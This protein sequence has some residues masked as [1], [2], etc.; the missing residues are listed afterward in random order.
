[1]AF[2]FEIDHPQLPEVLSPSD[3]TTLESKP[4]RC[5]DMCDDVLLRTVSELYL[6]SLLVVPLIF[7]GKEELSQTLT[8]DA[9]IFLKCRTVTQYFQNITGLHVR[10]PNS[11]LQNRLGT[12]QT[13]GVQNFYCHGCLS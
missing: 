2:A 3:R 13:K 8:P 9:N 6:Y 7:Y 4:P 5:W 10:S 12:L 11:D 1:M